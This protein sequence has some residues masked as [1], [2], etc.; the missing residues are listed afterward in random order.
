MIYRWVILALVG[1]ASLAQSAVAQNVGGEAP[2]DEACLNLALASVSNKELAQDE[3]VVAWLVKCAAHPSWR[4]C[5]G[6]DAFVKS[7]RRV[8]PVICENKSLSETEA[9]IALGAFEKATTQA[10]PPTDA[11][12]ARS[13]PHPVKRRKGSKRLVERPRGRS[14]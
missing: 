2:F 10:P 3:R 8:S 14:S 5:I 4:I 12:V 1:F 11:M 6:A 7:E 9:T 13:A